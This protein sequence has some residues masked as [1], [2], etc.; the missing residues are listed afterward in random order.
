LIVYIYL[1]SSYELIFYAAAEI[2]SSSHLLHT[3]YIE[4]NSIYAD[5]LFSS[6]SSTC[7]SFV[8]IAMS[9]SELDEP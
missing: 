4:S 8:L 7:T 9:K 6:A 1:E 2:T 5:L 3:S